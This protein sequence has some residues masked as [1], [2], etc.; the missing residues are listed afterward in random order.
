[1]P[2]AI[3]AAA[4]EIRCIPFIR[5]SCCKLIARWPA[6]RRARELGCDVVV[7]A[8]EI[9]EAEVDVLG[10][11]GAIGLAQPA[12]LEPPLHHAELHRLRCRVEIG[13]RQEH[14]RAY[15]PHVIERFSGNQ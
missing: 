9:A 10:I 12:L 7:E 11:P 6:S 2:A 3:T 13:P 8:I 15:V 5:S 4:T 1:M 14:G